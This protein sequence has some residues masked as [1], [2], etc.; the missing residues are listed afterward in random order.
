MLPPR[1]SQGADGS[2]LLTG[3]VIEDAGSY[4]CNASNGVSREKVLHVSVEVVGE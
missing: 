2:L 4:F 1:A 3:L